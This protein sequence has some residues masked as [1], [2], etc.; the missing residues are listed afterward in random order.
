MTL[1]LLG[2]FCLSV[3]LF[4][5][6]TSIDHYL[7]L[8]LS[9]VSSILAESRKPPVREITRLTDGEILCNVVDILWPRAQL[10]VKIKVDRTQDNVSYW[11]L[12]KDGMLHLRNVDKK[13]RM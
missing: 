6:L 5:V 3:V 4:C 2:I 8:Y 13:Q 12:R 1:A 7:Q 9:V 10:A 11:S